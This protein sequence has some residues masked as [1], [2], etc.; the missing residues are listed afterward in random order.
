MLDV[1][2]IREFGVEEI[3]AQGVA[4][5]FVDG[6]R[7]VGLL[8]EHNMIADIDALSAKQAP[9]RQLTDQALRLATFQPGQDILI[10]TPPGVQEEKAKTNE[11]IELPPVPKIA[12]TIQKEMPNQNPRTDPDAIASLFGFLEPNG[13]QT[14][15]S[16]KPTRQL[17]TAEKPIQYQPTTIGTYARVTAVTNANESYQIQISGPGVNTILSISEE[18]DISLAIALLEK[19]RRQ[20]KS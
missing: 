4:K 18:E 10:N 20:L 3:N 13:S 2:L 9:R 12:E 11:L 14:T 16:E 17:T 6:A 1:M 5:A 7:M 19:I 15:P 8:D